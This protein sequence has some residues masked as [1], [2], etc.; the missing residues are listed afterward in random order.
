[1]RLGQN[2]TVFPELRVATSAE[3]R[4]ETSNGKPEIAAP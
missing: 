2:Q 4:T 1:M 3:S